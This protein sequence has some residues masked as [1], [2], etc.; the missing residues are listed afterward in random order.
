MW[1][2]CYAIRC[3]VSVLPEWCDSLLASWPHSAAGPRQHPA[4]SPLQMV[5]VGSILTLSEGSAAAELTEPPLWPAADVNVQN[6]VKKPCSV[7]HTHT[8][9]LSLC[10]LHFWPSCFFCSWSTWALS[11]M[12]LFRESST[13]RRTSWS[14]QR[15]VSV[16]DMSTGRFY[17]TSAET[18]W[19]KT[20]KEPSQQ[21]WTWSL[22]GEGNRLS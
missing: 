10:W 1:V 8:H 17:W 19:T 18:G 16:T 4:G 5:P 15:Q 3:V 7:V 11:L 22:K 2:I 13:S 6:Q 21:S 12:L 14:C 9:T 20:G